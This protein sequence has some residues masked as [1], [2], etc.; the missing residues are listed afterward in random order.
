MNGNLMKPVFLQRLF[1]L[2]SK[3]VI[4]SAITALLGAC[5]FLQDR[6]DENKGIQL[7]SLRVPEGYQIKLLA[8]N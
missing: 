5:G 8:D 4:L 1:G 2:T 6:R 7:G 3:F